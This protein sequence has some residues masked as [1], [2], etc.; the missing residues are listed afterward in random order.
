MLRFITALALMLG[1]NGNLLAAE[2][3]LRIAVASNFSE[4]MRAL[5]QRFES[6]TGQPLRLIFGSTGKLYAQIRNGAPFDI[7]FAADSKRPLRL[8]Q[9]G[10]IIPGSRFSYARGQLVLWSPT[11]SSPLEQLQQAEGERYLALANPKLAPYG[12][13]AQ[14]VLQK[15]GLWQG[16]QR[17]IVR[18]ENIGQTF[19]F[20]HSGNAELGF[21]ALAQLQQPEQ[22]T[23]GYRW[24]IPLEDYD[25]IIQQAVLLNDSA[26]ARAFIEFIASDEAQQLITEYGYLTPGA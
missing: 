16:L 7:F 19:Q 3:P 2:T 6:R 11:L 17:R 23:P 21:V 4:P 12:L 5:S 8:E 20:V 22:S 18:G 26:A 15:L 1:L 13:A 24:A 25:P 14:Q 9:E 10:R